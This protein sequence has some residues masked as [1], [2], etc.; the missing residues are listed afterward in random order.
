MR[1]AAAS[2]QA[3]TWGAPEYSPR[4]LG[5]LTGLCCA[6]EGTLERYKGNVSDDLAS[7]RDLLEANR[8]AALV[9]A[10]LAPGLQ[11]VSAEKWQLA[12]VY[13]IEKVRT[14]IDAA[15]FA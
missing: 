13:D 11:V 1:A 2:L 7:K 5:E 10:H 3:L 12:H 9:H 4:D 6:V 15:R 14:L 8:L